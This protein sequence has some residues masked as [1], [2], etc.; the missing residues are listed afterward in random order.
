VAYYNPSAI[1][2]SYRSLGTAQI[3]YRSLGTA[4]I[5]TANNLSPTSAT[6]LGD[7]DGIANNN[8]YSTVAIAAKDNR[9]A[10]VWDHF[11]SFIGDSTSALSSYRLA[12]N[13]SPDGGTTWNSVA[14]SIPADLGLFNAETG[15]DD[16]WESYDEDFSSELFRRL[17]PD[18]TLSKDSSNNYY[19]HVV[20]H[21]Q[22]I[23]IKA[24]AILLPAGDPKTDVGPD[25][26]TAGH[27]I[28][29]A[30]T[31]LPASN[32]PG[33]MTWHGV[34]MGNDGAIESN[35]TYANPN[36]L[37]KATVE[38]TATHGVTDLTSEYF[39]NS[40]KTSGN[41]L[42]RDTIQPATVFVGDHTFNNGHKNR[43]QVVYLS[44]DAVNSS[45]YEVRYNGFELG[46]GNFPYN[47]S[48][49][50]DTSVRDSDCDSI[51]DAVEIARPPDELDLPDPPFCYSGNGFNNFKEMN[52]DGPKNLNLAA[53]QA[54]YIPDYLDT[55]AD[56]D[57]L[58]DFSD[59]EW[60]VSFLGCGPGSNCIFL[61]VLMKN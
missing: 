24:N 12:Q 57:G 53:D 17:Q 50:P 55:D 49:G 33:S 30:Y 7:G 35:P 25:R 45:L 59:A 31:Q 23:N 20:W 28:L 9:V 15:N 21:A 2:I 6:K 41:N 13:F 39:Y 52:C 48:T 43:L 46:S 16:Y 11:R 42:G 18:V 36:G 32:N 1:Q 40:Y 8:N 44:Q 60:R 38:Y 19:A 54:D 5:G 56:G 34:Q 22:M 29:Y 51:S 3:S 4:N 27:D 37:I 10:V 26:G 47:I 58:P 61:P 14:R